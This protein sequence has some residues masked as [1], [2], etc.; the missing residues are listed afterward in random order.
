[1]SIKS[2]YSCWLNP[3]HQFV[4]ATYVQCLKL[5]SWVWP[6]TGHLYR[7]MPTND[8]QVD[9]NNVLNNGL[10]GKQICFM[11]FTN[12]LITG[13]PHL[14]GYCMLLHKIL[15]SGGLAIDLR[16]MEPEHMK[17]KNHSVLLAI[18]TSQL[19]PAV[20]IT[21]FFGGLEVAEFDLTLES[22]G[23]FHDFWHRFIFLDAGNLCCLLLDCEHSNFLVDCVS[24]LRTSRRVGSQGTIGRKKNSN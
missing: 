14:F 16:K 13:G 15:R 24:V 4:F 23:S 22:S 8:S 9:T 21:L 17:S 5:A 11:E 6:K 2:H 3:W 19:F 7:A 12:Q 1:M 10:W 20:K 18:E